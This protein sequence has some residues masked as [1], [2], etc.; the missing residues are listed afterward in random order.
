MSKRV[1]YGAK[2]CFLITK[3]DG[4]TDMFLLNFPNLINRSFKEFDLS[5]AD[6]SGIDLSCS[7]FANANLTGADLSGS[8]LT[9]CD[10]SGASISGARFD[11]SVLHGCTGLDSCRGIVN[12]RSDFYMASWNGCDFSGVD[13]GW[14]EF[15]SKKEINE[16]FEGC[17]GIDGVYQAFKVKT[18]K[19]PIKSWNN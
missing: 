2:S 18:M 1:D 12:D 6:L 14:V 3:K 16:F 9:G 7:S 10:F 19:D 11:G 13:L 15:P 4:K 17:K 5:G 8:N